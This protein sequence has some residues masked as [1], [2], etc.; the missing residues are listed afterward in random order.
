M[1]EKEKNLK[2]FSAFPYKFCKYL[3]KLSPNQPDLTK[4]RRPDIFIIVFRY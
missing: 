3:C 2:L 1:K 4:T